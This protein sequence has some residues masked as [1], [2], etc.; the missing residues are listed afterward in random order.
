M[1]EHEANGRELVER[2]GC[3]LLIRRT[4]VD[5]QSGRVRFIDSAG[6]ETDSPL[7]R[8]ADILDTVQTLLRDGSWRARAQAMSR[9][10]EQAREATDLLSLFDIAQSRTYD[11]RSCDASQ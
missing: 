1:S 5:P 10:L 6:S 2:P 8:H 11:G 4:R 3:G 7:P 9:K